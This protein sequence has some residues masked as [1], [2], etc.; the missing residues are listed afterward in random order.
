M[1][2]KYAKYKA[3]HGF[4]LEVNEIK[5][6]LDLEEALLNSLVILSCD[7]ETSTYDGKYPKG[8]KYAVLEQRKIV[9]DLKTK[10]LKITTLKA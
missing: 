2:S 1:R 9:S 3:K 6:T 5:R 7:N 4:A 8:V 10:L